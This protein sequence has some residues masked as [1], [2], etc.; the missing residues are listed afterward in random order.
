VCMP[1]V[2]RLL[3]LDGPEG[4]AAMEV[5]GRAR[6]VSLALLAAERVPLAPGDWVRVHT[7][8]ALQRIDES[9]ARTEIAFLRDMQRA[10]DSEPMEARP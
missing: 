9:E 2:G 1:V 3:S 4:M 6:R 10:G 7:G 5:D 8:L